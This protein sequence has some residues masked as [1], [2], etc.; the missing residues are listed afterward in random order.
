MA[1]STERFVSRW[2][3]I[4]SLLG[5]AIGAGNIWRFPRVAA[6]NGGGAFL[7]PWVLFLFLWSLPLM[8]MEFGM[9]R[10]TRRGPVGA[11]RALLGRLGVIPGVFVAFCTS[12]I[13]FYY[14]VVTGWC[15]YYVVHLTLDFGA[16]SS[17]AAGRWASLSRG[18]YTGLA[19][20]AVALG[21]GL[22]IVAGGVAKGLERMN[23]LLIPL[24]F[25]LLVIAAVAGISLPGG[26]R[27]LEYLFH[28]DPARLAHHQ[29][30]LEALSQ[31][32]WSTGAG[33]GLILTYAVYTSRREDVMLNSLVAGVGNN[34]AS[35]LAALAILPAVF[36]LAGPGEAEQA[37]SGNTGLLF[38]WMPQ[39]FAKLAGGQALAVVFFLGVTVAALSSMLAMLEMAT[40]VMMDFGLSRLKA[41]AVVGGLGLAAGAPSAWSLAVFDNQDWVWGLGLMVS[42]AL[43]TVA[44]LRYGV[45]RF[46]EDFLRASPGN[47]K[48][49]RWFEIL[50]VA[51]LPLEFIALIVWWFWGA[52]R[53]AKTTREWLSPFE[54]FSVGTCLLQWTAVLVVGAILSGWI[55]RRLRRND[56]LDPVDPVKPGE[57]VDPARIAQ[58]AEGAAA[59]PGSPAGGASATTRE[60]TAGPE[61]SP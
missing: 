30:W 34:A 36:A 53:D 45:R 56:P 43:F 54:T 11:F 17:D 1:S 28:V 40:R 31:S 24:L 10:A 6:A 51:L 9:G 29:T 18:S 21:G 5:M 58:P 50:V 44:A 22:L 20:H 8:L 3:L 42:G 59:L 48:V 46:R 41:V 14:A 61:G 55:H 7:I 39:L 38:V 13:L 12:G 27:G 35:L 57:S 23:K 60:G 19:F 32:A 52:I 26:T 16:V 37:L 47:W 33:W 49:G 25:V 2:G 15:A 4:A